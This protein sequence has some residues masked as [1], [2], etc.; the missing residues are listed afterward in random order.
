MV[1]ADIRAVTDHTERLA[2]LDQDLTDRPGA[3]SPRVPE[4]SS[5]LK[6]GLLLAICLFATISCAQRDQSGSERLAAVCCLSP[7]HD[8]RVS[9]PA[10]GTTGCGEA[11]AGVYV[12][13]GFIF[14][15]TRE[16]AVGVAGVAVAVVRSG[17]WED[18]VYAPRRR[19]CPT[20]AR[21]R[22]GRPVS[23]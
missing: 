17:P 8:R 11:L 19:I 6:T 18:T 2:R 20:W 10:R 4:G 23:G 9:R 14:P 16:G 5:R 22:S 13:S 7:S 15:N 1:Q 21:I 3:A 12:K